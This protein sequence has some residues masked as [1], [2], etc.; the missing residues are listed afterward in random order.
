VSF[1]FEYTYHMSTY[2]ARS[3][4]FYQGFVVILHVYA[5]R[6]CSVNQASGCD[7]WS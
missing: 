5:F 6:P 3:I 4:H 1:V 2:S 7:N